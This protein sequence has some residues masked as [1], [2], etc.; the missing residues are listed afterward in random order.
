MQ[1]AMHL[2]STGAICARTLSYEDCEFELVENASN[3]KAR[4]AYNSS[5]ELWGDLLV[6]LGDRCAQSLGIAKK[7]RMIEEIRERGGVLSEELQFHEVLHADS[8][9]EDDD[10]SD[11]ED[12]GICEQKALRRKYRN[13]ASKTLRGLFWSANQVSV[14]TST[15]LYTPNTICSDSFFFKEIF[16]ISLHRIQS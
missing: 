5:A 3:E 7:K 1:H 10:Y 4:I 11:D 14:Y 13:R 8:D 16:S 2:K 6:A 15:K 9:D 12:S